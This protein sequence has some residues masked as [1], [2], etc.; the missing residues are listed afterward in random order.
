MIFGQGHVMTFRDIMFN[1]IHV[2]EYYV[3]RQG[4]GIPDIQVRFVHCYTDSVCLSAV[5]IYWQTDSIV[6]RSSYTNQHG[7]L[8]WINGQR[9]DF[10]LQLKVTL[11]H[12]R[13][14]YKSLTEIQLEVIDDPLNMIHIRVQQSYL[15]L[16]LKLKDTLCDS[17]SDIGGNCNPGTT[18]QID[19]FN[20]NW[21]VPDTDSLFPIISTE[22]GY[23]D[24]RNIPTSGYGLYFNNTGIT[25]GFLTN[26]IHYDI[27]FTLEIFIRPLINTGVI[28][29]HYQSVG[30]TLYIE[31]TFRILIGTT[32]LDT[33]ISVDVDIWHHV[34]VVWT[35][36]STQLSVYIYNT[37]LMVKTFMVTQ[38]TIFN[39]YGYLQLG[40]PFEWF[41]SAVPT[42]GYHHHFNGYIDEVRVWPKAFTYSDVSQGQM[43]KVTQTTFLSL[44]WS[45]NDGH[46]MII[47]DSVGKHHITITDYGTLVP[48]VLWVIS[49]LPL[50][51]PTPVAFHTNP[52]IT[53][54]KEGELRCKSFITAVSSH[55]DSW[56]AEF[57]RVSCVSD[58][59]GGLN[60]EMAVDS[61]VAISD[62]LLVDKSTAD[63]V[64][65]Q[66][67]S[68]LDGLPL[69]GWTG[70]DCNTECLFGDLSSSCDCSHGYWGANCSNICPGD[71][72]NP[73][74]NHGRCDSDTGTCV[75]DDNFVSSE[76]NQCET[77]WFGEDCVVAVQN[78]PSSQTVYYGSFFSNGHLTLVDGSSTKFTKVGIFVFVSITNIHIEVQ[79]GPCYNYNFCV[80]RVAM[81][82]H[83]KLVIFS[84][85]HNAG[86][87][88]DG[89]VTDIV[90]SLQIATGYH[91]IRD[92]IN[93]LRITGPNGFVVNVYTEIGY[94]NI[95]T[96]ISLTHC[97]VIEGFVGLCKAKAHSC[98][99]QDVA[100]LIEHIGLAQT[101]STT[102]L[103][104]TTQD[105]LASFE[106]WIVS[107]DLSLFAAQST[108]ITAMS[109]GFAVQLWHQGWLSSENLI[110]DYW[111]SH[112]TVTIE[113]LIYLD[114]IDATG[115]NG[116]VIS[117]GYNTAISVTIHKGWF[118]VVY[119]GVSYN[120]S[121]DVHL[122][123]WTQVSLIYYRQTGVLIFHY[124]Y[125]DDMTL[126][127]KISIGTG[128]F[129]MEGSLIVGSWLR[130]PNDITP[131]GEGYFYGT[132][133]RVL[134]WQKVCSHSELMFH[135]KVDVYRSEVDLVVGWS[136]KEGTGFSLTDFVNN[137]IMAVSTK[138]SRWVPSE[139]VFLNPLPETIVLPTTVDV[140]DQDLQVCKDIMQNSSIAEQC[141]SLPNTMKYF[142]MACVDDIVTSKSDD[143]K[144]DSALDVSSLCKTALDLSSLPSQTLCNEFTGRQYPI[145]NGPNCD[146]KCVFGTFDD[147]N[148]ICGCDS[149]YWGDSCDQECNG[150][151]A[152][153]CNNHGTCSQ[154][155]GS[156]D[157]RFNYKGDDSCSS[158]STGYAGTN[159][160][161]IPEIPKKSYLVCSV[162]NNAN[163]LNFTGHSVDVKETGIHELYNTDNF[164][165]AV[166]YELNKKSK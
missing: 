89:T 144:L 40:S 27:D 101:L 79:T 147:T 106:K 156:C 56:K 34:T 65:K 124:I 73:C 123:V 95:H 148:Q 29:N 1:F 6:I 22:G 92:D 146:V 5:G 57:F 145:W 162:R 78:L 67:C 64:A 66:A 84:P 125:G 129:S 93:V 88:I 62:L 14:T 49:S 74:H 97:D 83:G 63:W 136:F 98:Q 115:G 69:L 134:I 31:R 37:V 130:T 59:A 50:I 60:L 12:T 23:Q 135:W 155:T 21:K 16:I 8:V 82:I 41:S 61:L 164:R 139:I 163:F 114:H 80:I 18:V 2:G 54:Q 55:T 24:G 76:C 28:L 122:N 71:V 68:L 166:S 119:A 7:F 143:N 35:S 11:T 157:C 120:T 131:P 112:E 3:T 43:L 94:L 26:V 45:F 102:N 137:L 33:E 105:I 96:S 42:M 77:G 87:T 47:R 140:S 25:S 9:F 86:V 13:I 38:A 10:S 72:L 85:L 81:S 48:P 117:Y 116:T 32:V 152:T 113:T 165:V 132:I 30:F 100:C 158:C 103:I 111:T 118:F 90:T 104:V 126:T 53:A 58:V 15:S 150:G 99:P 4:V 160:D 75:C 141:K 109:T 159:C 39:N 52:N 151:W 138:Y 70:A 133:K 128:G 153:P 19:T 17:Q 20:T 91:L 108:N 154:S 142:Y 46:G 107:P 110:T 51:P 36:S 127:S 149:G 121:I 161:P 44:H